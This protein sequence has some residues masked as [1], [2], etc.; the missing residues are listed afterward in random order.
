MKFEKYLK[1][2]YFEVTVEFKGSGNV[3]TFDFTNPK[4][5]KQARKEAEHMLNKDWGKGKYEIMS[6]RK[7]KGN[8]GTYQ[9]KQEKKKS[10]YDRS[11][12]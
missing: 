7:E 12:E 5:K 6:I 8:P 10:R 11:D 2:D 9:G 3:E 1:E 4:N